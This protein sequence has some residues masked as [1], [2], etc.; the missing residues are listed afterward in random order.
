MIDQGKAV[1]ERCTLKNKG[2]LAEMSSKIHA[3]CSFRALGKFFLLY[4]YLKEERVQVESC[5]PART[6]GGLGNAGFQKEELCLCPLEGGSV[7]LEVPRLSRNRDAFPLWTVR[8]THVVMCL[9]HQL[10]ELSAPFVCLP[11][12]TS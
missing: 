2:S 4:E 3:C 5:T 7:I 9:S 8:L 12:P 11:R 10:R 6:E 1:G